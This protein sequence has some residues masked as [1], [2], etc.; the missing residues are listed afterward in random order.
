MQQIYVHVSQ[1]GERIY[2][3]GHADPHYMTDPASGAALARLAATTHGQAFEESD[4]SG[5]ERAAREDVGHA[6]AQARVSAYSRIPLAPWFVLAGAVPL[7]FLL[8]RRNA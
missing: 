3:H 6:A 1:P 5:I 2:S 8:W 7:A 4:L